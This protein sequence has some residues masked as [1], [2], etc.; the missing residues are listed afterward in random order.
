MNVQ[1]GFGKREAQLLKGVAIFMMLFHHLLGFPKWIAD[2]NMYV[3]LSDVG[4]LL[5]GELAM[6]C[7]LCVGL[8]I[9]M[10]GYGLCR[11]GVSFRSS[12]GRV[13]NLLLRYWFIFAVFIAIGVL[14]GEPLPSVRL[15]LRQAFGIST[16]TGYDWKYRTTIHPIFAWYVSVYILFMLSLPLL[17]RLVGRGF[18]ADMVVVHCV[19]YLL[20]FSMLGISE[21]SSE[22]PKDLVSLVRLYTIYAPVGM[23]GFLVSKYGLLEPSGLPSRFERFSRWQ[24]SILGACLLFAGLVLRN[25]LKQEFGLYL[26]VCGWISLETVC[27]VVFVV[28]FVLLCAGG[29]P[30]V[31]ERLLMVFSRHNT[32]I[33]FLHALYFTPLLT[34]QRAAYF[35]RLALL[36]IVTAAFSMLGLACV[37]D[38]S[39]EQIG[40][41][42]RHVA[43]AEDGRA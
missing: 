39:Y 21:R 14:V 29:V 40:R 26:L 32:S 27:V 17:K 35:P 4:S 9:F 37:L 31:L 10:T 43:R 7:K 16:A 5:V 13:C 36:V 18:L 42:V 25:V 24:V 8:Y 41:V 22:V 19:I 1:I 2:E 38:W 15:L 23:T 28:G 12:L 3:C 11:S 20:G 34:F 6:A 33:W 30:A